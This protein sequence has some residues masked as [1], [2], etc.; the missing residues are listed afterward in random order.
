LK[1]I[2]N[3]MRKNRKVQGLL[4]VLVAVV[5]VNAGFYFMRTAREEAKIASLEEK[6][7][8]LREDLRK[9]NGEYMVRYSFDKGRS[10]I[11]AFKKLLPAHADYISIIRQVMRLAKEDGTKCGEFGTEKR[12]VQHEGDLDQ[13]SFTMPVSGNYTNVRK[14]I[15]DVERSD[16]F[17]N[18]DN[19]DLSTKADSDEVSLSIGL[20]TYVRS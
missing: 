19:L 13:L 20:S 11:D 15:Y 10:D 7:R 18:I 16:L 14:F 6:S 1:E 9:N 3:I 12:A 17:L 4:L 8:A 2:L 5:A